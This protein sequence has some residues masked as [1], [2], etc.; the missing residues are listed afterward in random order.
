MTKNRH[1]PFSDRFAI[2]PPQF[3]GFTNAAWRLH[4]DLVGVSNW[5]RK[6]PEI[7]AGVAMNSISMKSPMRTIATLLVFLT[8]A[9]APVAVAQTDVTYFSR[10]KEMYAIERANVRSGPG[11]NFAK[12]GL[13][14][15]DQKVRVT[16][17]RGDW[18]KLTGAFQAAF[19]LRLC[20]AAHRNQSFGPKRA[21]HYHRVLQ[22]NDHLRE[23]CSLPW[24]NTKRTTSWPWCLYTDGWLPP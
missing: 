3:R 21:R 20:A 6:E 22:E 9:D 5:S 8:W 16:A 13:L 17:R 10:F 1:S 15:V 11:T 24:S 12:V 18:F 4:V 14:D 23:R 19:A 7:V 2:C